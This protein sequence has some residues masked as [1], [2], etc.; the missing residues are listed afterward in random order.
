[1]K[2]TYQKL[3]EC[4]ATYKAWG[5]KGITGS[6]VVA[7]GKTIFFMLI[8]SVIYY[9]VYVIGPFQENDIFLGESN[10]YKSDTCSVVG[11]NLHGELST[12]ISHDPNIESTS[13]RG[14]VSSENILEIIR[15][16]DEDSKIKAI[17]V[18]VDSG[19]GSGVAGEEIFKAL[20]NTK[21]PTV[22]YIRDIGASASYLA[23]S[24][25]DKIFASK[26]SEVGSIGVTASYLSNV[27][28]NKKEGY[29]YEELVAGKYKEVGSP[30]KP[31]SY[32]DKQLLMRDVYVMYTNLITD[33]SINRNIPL[34][35]VKL[36]ADGSTVT[37]QKAKELGLVD[38]IGGLFE[39][40]NYIEKEIGDKPEI[41]WQ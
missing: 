3:N 10:G 15:Q 35:K 5:N 11:I 24:S 32:E 21:K 33:I 40:L 7:V 25:A 2:N 16:A 27:G 29:Q 6:F 41:C 26:Y 18:E 4:W 34:D 20:E 13:V 8:A 22:A 28:S 36:F 38:E 39:V 19:G 30:N 37:G 17:V 14:G 23:I 1:M 9:G 31:L 12:F